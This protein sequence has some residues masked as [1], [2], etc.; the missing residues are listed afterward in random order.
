M[1]DKMKGN[2]QNTAQTGANQFRPNATATPAQPEEPQ[3][4]EFNS[5]QTPAMTPQK[6]KP[7]LPKDIVSNAQKPKTTIDEKNVPIA[8]FFG[9]CI[10]IVIIAIIVRFFLPSVNTSQAAKNALKEKISTSLPAGV[11]L[12]KDDQDIGQQDFNIIHASS[13]DESEIW[14]W[15]Y[16]DEDGDYVQVLVNGKPISEAFMV[17]HKPRTFIVPAVGNVQIKGVRDG[18]GGISYAVRYGINGTTYFNSTLPG[19]FNTYTLKQD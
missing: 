8:N 19:Q 10:V 5:F 3:G 18:V 11:I 14:V 13:D 1:N 6:V 7:K 15:D 16:A 4:S 2:I 17:K 9:L 12:L